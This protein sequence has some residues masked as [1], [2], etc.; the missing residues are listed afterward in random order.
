MSVSYITWMHQT[1]SPVSLPPVVEHLAASQPTQPT[2]AASSQQQTP[3]ANGTAASSSSSSASPLS[4]TSSSTAAYDALTSLPPTLLPP[5]PVPPPLLQSKH[6]A[7]TP[8]ILLSS[9]PAPPMAT[10]SVSPASRRTMVF[11]FVFPVCSLGPPP[12]VPPPP[13]SHVV[14]IHTYIYIFIYCN[15]LTERTTLLCRHWGGAERGRTSVVPG[16]GGGLRRGS[17]RTI[18]IIICAFTRRRRGLS[19]TFCYLCASLYVLC[20]IILL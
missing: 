11:S 3:A 2:A 6:H 16:E 10:P 8:N 20:M 19:M 15:G 17:A 1:D 18:I 13:P 7:R 12:I 4:Q 9:P 5:P 14:G